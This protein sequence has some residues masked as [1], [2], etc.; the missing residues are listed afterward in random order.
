MKDQS[1]DTTLHVRPPAQ[2]ARRPVLADPGGRRD[3]GEPQALHP[4]LAAVQLARPESYEAN[5]AI[6]RTYGNG[7]NTLPLVGIVSAPSGTTL[8]SPA[9]RQVLARAFAQAAQTQAVVRPGIAPAGRVVSYA[10]T[11]DQRLLSADHRSAYG[12][13]YPPSRAAEMGSPDLV[14]PVGAALRQGLPAGWIVQVTGLDALQSGGDANGP[15]VLAETLLGAVG[16]LAVL[17]FVFGSLLALVPLL[18]AAVSILATFLIIL[19]LT[20]LTEVSVIVQY[21]VA[22]IG[23]GVALGGTAAPRWSASSQ[24]TR[25]APRRAGRPSA[26]SARQPPPFPACGWADPARWTSTSATPSTAASR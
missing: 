21:L 1:Y 2:A 24:P 13:V 14:T 9:A 25:P 4:P 12:L 20:E 18:I 23:L 15:G 8:D 5:Q 10:S 11:G 26:G 19:G 7:G 16:A 6:L 22:L 3:G 17:A